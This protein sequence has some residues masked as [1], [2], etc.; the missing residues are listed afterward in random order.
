MKNYCI[1][2]SKKVVASF[3][4][5]YYIFEMKFSNSSNLASYI[6]EQHP[7]LKDIAFNVDFESD[8]VIIKFYSLGNLVIQED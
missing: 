1:V 3:K 7:E 2:A 6:V 8:D 4:M 5:D